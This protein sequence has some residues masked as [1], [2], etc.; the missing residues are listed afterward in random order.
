APPSYYLEDELKAAKMS[1]P[2]YCSKVCE[3]LKLCVNLKGMFYENQFFPGFNTGMEPTEI[4]CNKPDLI[5]HL[6]IFPY[7]VRSDSTTVLQRRVRY[8]RSHHAEIAT[9]N[10]AYA[11]RIFSQ[12]NLF[13][14][15]RVLKLT[16]T[17]INNLTFDYTGLKNFINVKTAIVNLKTQSNGGVP[18]NLITNLPQSL[19]QLALRVSASDIIDFYDMNLQFD[20]LQ[21]DLNELEIQLYEGDMYEDGDY[22]NNGFVKLS[23]LFQPTVDTLRVQFH[24]RDIFTYKES[25]NGLR[26]N[27]ESTL[28]NLEQVFDS[29]V[30][31]P[32]H[33]DYYVYNSV[34]H[35]SVYHNLVHLKLLVQDFRRKI[36]SISGSSP[37]L[38]YQGLESFALVGNPI[39]IEDYA[40]DVVKNMSNILYLSLKLHVRGIET[41]PR[42]PRFLNS[43]RIGCRR[44]AHVSI[45]FVDVGNKFSEDRFCLHF[46]DGL[47]N[48]LDDDLPPCSVKRLWVRGIRVKRNTDWVKAAEEYGI[49]VDPFGDPFMGIEYPQSVEDVV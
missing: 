37:S 42:M 4:I 1:Q 3:A 30:W 25:S 39:S 43:L 21:A 29:L 44:L 16:T 41:N 35:E 11:T 22:L 18:V 15:V 6:D 47:V 36:S 23:Q 5:T 20:R 49:T 24:R 32:G 34:M 48:T 13:K 40:S 28:S 19:K 38:F 12:A 14:N 10:S 17:S 26:L 45:S 33:T 31:K 46:V 2:S 27:I 9:L 8:D 7:T